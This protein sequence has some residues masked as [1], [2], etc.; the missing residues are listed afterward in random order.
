M[1]TDRGSRGECWRLRQREAGAVSQDQKCHQM[2]GYQRVVV[3]HPHLNRFAALVLLTPAG[4]ALQAWR[5]KL[6]RLGAML[7][8]LFGVGM[9]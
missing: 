8:A 4:V 3:R 6:P 5:T 1:C 7:A 2:C 9:R